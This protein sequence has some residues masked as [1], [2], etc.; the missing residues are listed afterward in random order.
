MKLRN[1]VINKQ[2]GLSTR[3]RIG[4]KKVKVKKEDVSKQ[5]ACSG[6]Q[7]NFVYE[8]GR[9]C[10]DPKA[11]SATR[12]FE[13]EPHAVVTVSYLTSR[14]DGKIAVGKKFPIL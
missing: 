9:R 10:P 13:P 6:H 1:S 12:S 4:E 3:D 11:S 5:K 14:D 2:G 8:A 7:Y